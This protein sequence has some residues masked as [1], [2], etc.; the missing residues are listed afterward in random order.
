MSQQDPPPTVGAPTELAD[1]HE[2]PG[3]IQAGVTMIVAIPYLLFRELP[4]LPLDALVLAYERGGWR[5]TL[6]V[7]LGQV[8]LCGGLCGALFQ[9][10]S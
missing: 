5:W 6:A 7:L 4:T 10:M 8:L 3:C 2:M 1:A 9:V